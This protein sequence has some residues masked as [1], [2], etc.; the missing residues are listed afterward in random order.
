MSKRKQSIKIQIPPYRTP[1]NRWRVNIHKRLYSE[2]QSKGIK[3]KPT[4]RLE[5]R[6]D[7]CMPLK[8]LCMHDVDNRLKDIMDAA[9]GRMGGPKSRKPVNPIIPNDHQVFKVTIEKK[10]SSKKNRSMGH[11]HIMKYA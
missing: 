3:Y 4:D 9:Q 6:I 11:L 1:R 7:F 8:Q 2:A 10:L 5:L